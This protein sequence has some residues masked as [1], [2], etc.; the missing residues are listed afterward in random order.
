MLK[1]KIEEY[2]DI[3]VLGYLPEDSSMKIESRYLGLMQADEKLDSETLIARVAEEV[4]KTIDIDE[5]INMG[6]EIQC[7]PFELP[8]KRNIKVSIAYDEAFN[9]YYSENLKMLE[10]SCHVTYFSPLKD[11]EVPKS[12]LIYIG[13][14]YPE[15]YANQLSDNNEMLESIRKNAELGTYILAECGGFMYL[16][17]SIEGHSMANI[18]QGSAVMTDRLQRFGYVNVTMNKDTII[19]KKGTKLSGNEYH[20]SIIYSDSTPVFDIEKAM[21]SKSWQCGYENHNG[22]VLGAYAHV[23]FLGNIDSFRYL[24]DTVETKRGAL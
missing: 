14:G 11:K 21:G 17:S 1:E 3:K 2:I 13:G 15:L 24:L 10:H 8:K 18:L 9:F 20:R 5:I 4:E 22:N 16:V 6:K 23:N 19:G 12:D 7:T